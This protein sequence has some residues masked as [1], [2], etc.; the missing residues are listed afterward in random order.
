MVSRVGMSRVMIRD[1]LFEDKP[2][3]RENVRN[4][5]RR[6]TRSHASGPV[7]VCLCVPLSQQVS[8]DRLISQQV[9]REQTG[10]CR[11][12]SRFAAS[13]RARKAGG[14]QA[15]SPVRSARQRG[16]DGERGWNGRLGDSRRDGG[17]RG[18]WQHGWHGYAWQGGCRCCERRGGDGGDGRG[19]G[20]WPWRVF[21]GRR[22]RRG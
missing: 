18:G 20:G 21:R 19:G 22:G 17:G 8:Q 1:R 10:R 11:R 12:G 15:S 6:A 5:P 4:N 2:G 3:G 7:L 9:S 13:L 14:G 16:D